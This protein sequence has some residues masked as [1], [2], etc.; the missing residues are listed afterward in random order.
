MCPANYWHLLLTE[1]AVQNFITPTCHCQSG[2]SYLFDEV[3]MHSLAQCMSCTY[4]WVNLAIDVYH[5]LCL[6]QQPGWSEMGQMF[7]AANHSGKSAFFFKLDIAEKMHDPD[8]DTECTLNVFAEMLRSDLASKPGN[9]ILLRCRKIRQALRFAYGHI[10]SLL[11]VKS[12]AP[13]MA[14]CWSSLAGHAWYL[15]LFSGFTPYPLS[16]AS[17]LPASFMTEAGRVLNTSPLPISPYDCLCT[18][19]RAS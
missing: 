19:L 11:M 18:D 12:L 13:V 16:L 4:I 10:C 3:H 7:A 17:C 6:N 14:V 8:S 5:R 9:S 2:F 1:T 15:M